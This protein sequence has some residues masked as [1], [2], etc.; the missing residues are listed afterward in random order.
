MTQAWHP[1]VLNT[2]ILSLTAARTSAKR[3]LVQGIH[4]TQKFKFIPKARSSKAADNW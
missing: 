1:L 3:V 2:M 4:H